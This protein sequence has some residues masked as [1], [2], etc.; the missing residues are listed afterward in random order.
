MPNF[1]GRNIGHYADFFC[2]KGR[3]YRL[4]GQ[5]GLKTYVIGSVGNADFSGCRAEMRQFYFYIVDSRQG[6]LNFVCPFDKNNRAGMTI[7]VE[8][9]L[10]ELGD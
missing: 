10:L 8:A 6:L 7:I 4:L 9:D 3:K 2:R 5:V 1:G